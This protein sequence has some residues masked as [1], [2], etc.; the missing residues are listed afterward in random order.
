MILC[1]LEFYNLENIENEIY[2]FL[3]KIKFS[4][5]KKIILKT[6]FRTNLI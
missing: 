5:F 4:E 2:N 6:N 3:E 1:K